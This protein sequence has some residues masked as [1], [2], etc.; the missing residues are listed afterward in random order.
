[1]ADKPTY[2]KLE[3]RVKELEKEIRK[4]KSLV[5]A[6]RENEKRYRDLYENAPNAYFFISTKDGSILRC[7]TACSNL[8]GYDRDTLMGMKVLELYADNFYGISKAK[9]VFKHFK[10]GKSI[11]DI[12]LQMKHMEGHPIWISLSVEPVK[13]H[14][15]NVNESL[16]MLID[17]SDRKPS[18][19]ALRKKTHDLVERVKELNCLYG[20]GSLVERQGV[21]LEETFQEIV[22]LVPPSW[23]YPE[24]TCARIIIE[25]REWKTKNFRE[26]IW[27]Q[28]SDIKVHG[29]LIG[30]LEVCYLEEKPEI[31]DGPFLIEERNLINTVTKL[32][33]RI[34][35]RKQGEKALKESEEKYR[36]IFENIQDVYYEVSLDG[37]ILEISPSVKEVSKYSREELIGKSVYN[38][39]AHPE[40]RDGFVRELLENGR[41]TDYEIVLKNKDGLQ[42]HCSVYAKVS[43]NENGIPEKIIGSMFDVTRRKQMENELRESEAQKN[44]TI[45]CYYGQ[46]SLRRQGHE[47]HLG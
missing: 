12:E 16:L 37:I 23:Q 15:G 27:K 3:L 2:E 1:M 36:N 29:E 43:Y 18:E 20:I 35:E 6:L 33:G 14:K 44:C 25:G 32:T 8:L 11:R 26:T 46:D 22:D 31:A 47:N 34:I 39:Y 7:N 41:V 13:D 21:S 24:I 10:E 40:N 9:E 45:R 19:E 4:Y 5:K 28:T 30:N 38:L 42:R 17:I